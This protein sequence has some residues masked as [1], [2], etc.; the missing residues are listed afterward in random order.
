MV[1]II[2]LLCFV[3]AVFAFTAPTP[4]QDVQGG[5]E[6]LQ[7]AWN[8]LSKIQPEEKGTSGLTMRA[9]LVTTTG[10]INLPPDTM[11]YLTRAQVYD[12]FVS[13][14]YQYVL[15][16]PN[17]DT[18]YVPPDPGSTFDVIINVYIDSKG[19]ASE[20]WLFNATLP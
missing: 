2:A 10:P 16:L 15:Q 1:K 3:I 14:G 6:K 18:Y 19:R 8:L 20:V 11:S 5:V 4:A 9:T 12:A 7:R 13:A 17:L